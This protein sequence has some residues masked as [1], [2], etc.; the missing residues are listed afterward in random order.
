MDPG[1]SGLAVDDDA[2][3]RPKEVVDK[4]VDRVS[5]K[6]VDR[7]TIEIDGPGNKMTENTTKVKEVGVIK[8]AGRKWDTDARQSI[9]QLTDDTRRSLTAD[10]W[11]TRPPP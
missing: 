6:K 3:S 9:A 4:E 5:D 8:T 7:V 10:H 11:G 1:T 2:P